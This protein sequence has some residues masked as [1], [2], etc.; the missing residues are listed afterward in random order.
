MN[1]AYLNSRFR[2]TPRPKKERPLRRESRAASKG[3]LAVGI[4][5]DSDT[6][7]LEVD[8]SAKLDDLEVIGAV[9]KRGR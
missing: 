1:A 5:S 9:A 2:N 7:D 4:V 6:Q 3:G 8:Q